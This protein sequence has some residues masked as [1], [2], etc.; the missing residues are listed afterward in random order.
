MSTAHGKVIL[1]GEH[2]VVYGVPAIAVGIDRGARASVTPATSS[3]ASLRVGGWNI[4][5]REGETE[6]PLDRAF[7][8]VLGATRAA[9]VAVGAVHVDA[10]ADLPPGGGLGCSAA[11]GVAVARALDPAAAP[12]DIAARADAWERVFHGNPS[13]IDAA[14]SAMGGCVLFQRGSLEGQARAS[15][16]RIRVPGAVHLCIGNSGQASSTKSMVEAVARLRERRPETT[17][18]AFD[19]IHTLV[20]NAALALADGDR[21][22]IGQLLDLNQMLLSGLF[23]STPEIEQ[24]CGAARAAGALGAKLTGGGGGGCVVAL[25]DGPETGAAVLAAWKK[26]GFDGFQTT[27]GAPRR[28]APITLETAP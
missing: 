4:V 28:P 19:A 20:K 11:L 22:S 7:N 14:V 3:H 13:G 17:Q 24:M 15:I 21:R 8:G 25:V 23:V 16:Q 2:A 5:A 10:E 12:E 18:K 9:G 6:T 26:D 1:F 27:F